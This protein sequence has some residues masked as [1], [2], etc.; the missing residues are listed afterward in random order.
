ME[1]LNSSS[2][3]KLFLASLVFRLDGDLASARTALERLRIELV[4]NDGSDTLCDVMVCLAVLA[5]AAGDRQAAH[6]RLREAIRMRAHAPFASKLPFAILEVAGLTAAVDPIRASRLASLSRGLN[7]RGERYPIFPQ[8]IARVRQVLIDHGAD[9]DLP[10]PNPMP[11]EAEVVA[12][13]FA[14]LDQVT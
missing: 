9:P 3:Q 5:S 11:S 1:G 14:A 13:A 4:T 2:R 8:D 6:D 10:F 7:A 12:E